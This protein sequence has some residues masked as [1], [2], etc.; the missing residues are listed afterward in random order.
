MTG[1]SDRL[2]MGVREELRMTPRCLAWATGGMMVPFNELGNWRSFIFICVSYSH[3]Q[4]CSG[5]SL[6]FN[7]EMQPCS[8][9]PQCNIGLPVVTYKSMPA[10]RDV[11]AY[12]FLGL[13]FEAS[14]LCLQ[15]LNKHGS[16]ITV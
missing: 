10:S 1:L 16:H 8:Y 15:H 3:V 6:I 12:D 9:S 2:E 13:I 11:C 7:E 14:F 5:E 4:H